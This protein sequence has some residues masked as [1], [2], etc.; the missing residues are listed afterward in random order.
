[1]VDIGILDPA[2]GLLRFPYTI[3]RGVRFP[4]EPLEVMGFR[5]VAL[6]TREPYVVNEYIEAEEARVGQPHVLTGE[7]SKS[8]VFVPFVV[9]DRAIGV[10]SCRTS[11]GSTRSAT[12]TYAC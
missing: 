5:R 8:C 9:G 4:D 6:E 2:S 3:E 7:P 12:R 11:T 1:M 10:V